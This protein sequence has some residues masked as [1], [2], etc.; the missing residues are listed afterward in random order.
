MERRLEDIVVTD[1]LKAIAPHDVDKI[2]ISISI[3]EDD[4]RKARDWFLE[5]GVNAPLSVSRG[6]YV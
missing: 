1:D 6:R 2:I 4:Y 5:V 3:S